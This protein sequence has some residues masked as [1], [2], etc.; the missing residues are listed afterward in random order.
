MAMQSFRQRLETKQGIGIVIAL[1]S[2]GVLVTFDVVGESYSILSPTTA[3]WSRSLP[4]RGAGAMLQYRAGALS[5]S[6]C[7]IMN[8]G[9]GI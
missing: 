9:A 1:L 7:S 2:G 5:G 8:L 6:Q 4:P 3:L